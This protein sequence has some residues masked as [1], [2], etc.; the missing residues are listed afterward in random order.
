MPHTPGKKVTSRTYQDIRLSGALPCFTLPWQRC[1]RLSARNSL[2]THPLWDGLTSNGGNSSAKSQPPD[3]QTSK[4]SSPCCTSMLESDGTPE[5]HHELQLKKVP[6]KGWSPH[7][8][9][10]KASCSPVSTLL[11][12]ASSWSFLISGSLARPHQGSKLPIIFSVLSLTSKNYERRTSLIGA[13]IAHPIAC[14]P[15]LCQQWSVAYAS[16]PCCLS[17]GCGTFG[18]FSPGT[19]ERLTLSLFDVE[20]NSYAGAT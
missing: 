7:E 19:L 12:T 4:S 1:A 2:A 6:Q 13:N 9:S 5:P 8:A 18:R 15:G 20:P 16:F 3:L 14:G 10:R 17:A 11:L